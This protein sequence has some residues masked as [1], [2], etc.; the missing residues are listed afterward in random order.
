VVMRLLATAIG[1]TYRE[2]AAAHQDGQCPCGWRPVPDAD[3]EALRTWLGR[4]TVREASRRLRWRRLRGFLGQARSGEVDLLADDGTGSELRPVIALLYSVLDRLP[5]GPRAAWVLRYLLDE[6][7][8][9]VA[10]ICGCSLAT[11]KRRIAVAE[12]LL[13]PVLGDGEREREEDPR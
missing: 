13:A 3:I 11:G 1:S 5:A 7:L 8:D 4:I 6:P 10:A 9:G 2:V 12:R